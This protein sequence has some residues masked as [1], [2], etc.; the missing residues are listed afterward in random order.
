MINK[1]F[2]LIEKL[3]LN[4][5]NNKKAIIALIAFDLSP[6]IIIETSNKIDNANDILTAFTLVDFCIA[7][8]ILHYY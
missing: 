8:Y 7:I 1:N 2:S 5:K 3:L 6:V 4:K